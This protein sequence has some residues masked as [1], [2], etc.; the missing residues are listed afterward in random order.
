MIIKTSLIDSGVY[1][2]AVQRL[3]HFKTFA[4]VNEQDSEAAMATAIEVMAL[5]LPLANPSPILVFTADHPFSFAICDRSSGAVIF[6]G[7]AADPIGEG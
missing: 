6:M 4:C 1:C 7:R 5:G 2:S 3:I